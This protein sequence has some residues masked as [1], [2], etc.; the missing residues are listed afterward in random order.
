MMGHAKIS[1][2]LDNYGHV[3]KNMQQQAATT[4]DKLF[5]PKTG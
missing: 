5:R 3:M 1:T 2:T 4:F